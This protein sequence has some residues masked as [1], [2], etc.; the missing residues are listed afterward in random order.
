MGAGIATAALLSGL[1]VV[2]LEMTPE[3]AEAARLQRPQELGPEGLG[4]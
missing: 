4:K 1:K 3:A 2:M